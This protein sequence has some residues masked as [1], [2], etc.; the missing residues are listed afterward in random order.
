MKYVL[1]DAKKGGVAVQTGLP[2]VV[3]GELSEEGE[4]PGVERAAWGH[5]DES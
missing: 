2:S 3:V 1:M 4:T 5:R